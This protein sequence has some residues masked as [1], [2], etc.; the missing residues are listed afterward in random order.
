MAESLAESSM[1][2]VVDSVDELKRRARA[3]DLHAL[4]ELRDRG[5]FGGGVEAP[6]RGWPV[7][8]TQRRLWLVEQMTLGSGAYHIPIALRLEGTLDSGA[9]REALADVVGRHESLRTTFA[10]LDGELRQIVH[11][12][13]D[14]AWQE[15][16]LGGFAD[17]VERARRL[18]AEHAV[19]P[20]DLAAGPLL[21]A[22]V[23]R[24]DGASYLLLL[25]IHHVIADLIS[26]GILF[27]EWSVAYAA[28]C[29]GEAPTFPP[30]P[31]QYKD[32]AVWQN[33]LLAGEEGARH[34]SY[35]LAKLDGPLPPID[36]PADSP[37]PPLKTFRGGLH[38]VRIAPDRTEALRR[39]GLR[40][41]TTLFMVLAAVLKVL[42]YRYTGQ[43]DILVGCPLAGREHPDLE[44]QIGC[45]VSTVALR[46]RL[47]PDDAFETVL[48]RVAQTLL[49]AYEHQ[50]YPFDLLVEELGLARDLSR[51]PVF[52]VSLSLAHR[53][54]QPLRL[55][56][57]EVTPWDDGFASA[58]VDLSFDFYETGSGLDLAIAYCADL[59]TEARIARMANH[60]LCLAATAAARPELPIG[61]LHLMPPEEARRVLV[62][63]NATRRPY[64]PGETA[65]DLFE[66]QVARDPSAL[67]LRFDGQELSYGELD[68]RSRRIAAL[69]RARG[70]D[71]ESLVGLCMEPSLDLPCAFLGILR[72]GGV[73]LPLDPANPRGRLADMLDDARPR[74]VLVQAHLAADL[75]IPKDC[76]VRTVENAAAAE[77]PTALPKPE[78]EQAAYA[79]F[80]SGST[81]RPKAAVL[82][83]GGL[84]NVAREQDRLFAPGPG[85]RVLQFAAIGFDASV[86]EM[87]MALSQGSALCLAPRE[88]LLPGRALLETLERES[89]SIATLPP[90]AL[91]ALPD[92]A[93]P[94]LRVLTAAG[95]PCPAEAVQRWAPGR[96]FF[97]LYGPTETTIWATAARCEPGERIPSIGRP[98]ANTRVYI[99]DSRLAPVPVGV[100]GELCIA[101]IGLARHYLNRPELNAQR[102][103]PDPFDPGTGAR[104]YRTGDL[105]RWRPDGAIELSGRIDMQVKLRGY[106]IELGEI[107]AALS[108]HPMVREA[109][110]LA[111]ED[112]PGLTWLVGYVTPSAVGELPDAADLR[113]YLHHRLPDYMVP[114]RFVVLDELPVTTNGKIDRQ[115]LPPPAERPTPKTTEG[116][117]RDDLEWVLADL[118]AHVLRLEQVGT[119]DSF[120]E[121]GGDSLLATRIVSRLR[122]AFGTDL[123]IPGLF[124]AGSVVGLA[125][126]LRGLLPEG[127]ADKVAAALRRLHSMSP[128]EKAALREGG[129]RRA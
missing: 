102:F 42:L 54:G 80:T 38:R 41:G 105:A 15:I 67:A 23:I 98:I 87:L 112:R 89:I 22:A 30:L 78:V 32:F 16:D 107:E 55:G 121:L 65:I 13:A 20:F 46:D 74:L 40:H 49:E 12:G 64:P 4:Q 75:P 18:A 129:G 125:S 114:A 86:F 83:H 124:R 28:R 128:A 9:L 5:L 53:G 17:A 115:A 31:I 127:R 37:R 52:D 109:V 58:K 71:A 92:A 26:L 29:A 93:L 56:R 97:N 48:A 14:L 44:R 118:F 39:L 73:Y 51:S 50:S 82:T 2:S 113:E 119:L 33:R 116:S 24:P 99:L 104:L 61:Q 1:D 96:A 3:G 79:I 108:G 106:R 123:T 84:A 100:P 122:E 72:A 7:S 60:F 8:H 21:R 103:V 110:V 88:R 6:R 117:P 63:F 66:A 76:L 62:E 59:F 36:L 43:E 126:A 95:E 69:L 120:F 11:E 47:G 35:W 101:G 25:N 77:D 68:A 85:D 10:E 91:L 57:I 45:F 70:I 27:E 90:S 34:R 19:R 94:R 111:R 81:G